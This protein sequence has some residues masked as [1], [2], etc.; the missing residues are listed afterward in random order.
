MRTASGNLL[1]RD[2]L[3]DRGSWD[4][5]VRVIIDL[6]ALPQVLDDVK[7]GAG[8]F[9]QAVLQNPTIRLGVWV[10]QQENVLHGRLQVADPGQDQQ[11]VGD[12]KHLNQ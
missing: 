10:T 3:L 7:V 1:R 9:C 11:L 12:K 5:Y 2:L 6:V 4:V 8:G